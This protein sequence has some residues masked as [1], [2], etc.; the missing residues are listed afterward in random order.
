[1]IGRWKSDGTS[2]TPHSEL[3]DF[4]GVGVVGHEPFLAAFPLENKV[5]FLSHELGRFSTRRT[6]K[7]LPRHASKRIGEGRHG[8]EESS[9]ESDAPNKSLATGL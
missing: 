9:R 7:G 8:I 2:G 5:H 4:S 3:G 6:T 1:M